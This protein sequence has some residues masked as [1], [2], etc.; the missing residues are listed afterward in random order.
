MPPRFVS[1]LGEIRREFHESVGF[2]ALRCV[3]EEETIVDEAVE[4]GHCGSLGFRGANDGD[5][6]FSA[7]RKKV[8]SGMIRFVWNSS[9]CSGVALG[10]IQVRKSHG[11]R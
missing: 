7:G 3:T 9:A 5:R 6:T 2:S 1:V 8:G 10:G 11:G 4:R